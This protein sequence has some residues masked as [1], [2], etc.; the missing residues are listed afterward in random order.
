MIN[1]SEDHAASRKFV[2]LFVLDPAAD[3]LVP[4]RSYL[5]QSYLYKRALTGKC[6]NLPQGSEQENL[7]DYVAQLIMEYVGVIPS[8]RERRRVRNEMLRSQL[9]PKRTILG[10][11]ESMVCTT[12]NGCVTMLGWIDSLL[13]DGE[14]DRLLNHPF[15]IRREEFDRPEKRL[16]ALNYPPKEVGRGLSETLSI[17]SDDLD[18]KPFIDTLEERKEQINADLDKMV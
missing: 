4:A 18:P 14:Q 15:P 17:P 9:I 12:G 7:T 2:A 5:A 16:N 6:N 8:L 11:S 1:T 13:I 3:R 10:R